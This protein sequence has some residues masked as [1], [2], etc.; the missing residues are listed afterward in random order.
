MNPDDPRTPWSRLVAG[1][2]RADAERGAEAPY[3]FATRVAAQAFAAERRGAPPFE[4]FALRAL[5]I[6]CLVALLSLAANY[7]ALKTPA[8]AASPNETMMVADDGLAIVME[9]AAD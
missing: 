5:G 7:P 9:L 6:A 3:G 2:R 8:P 4:R 1:A